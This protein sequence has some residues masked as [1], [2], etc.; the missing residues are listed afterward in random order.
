M[1]PC[2]LR[3]GLRLIDEAVGK[4]EAWCDQIHT[5]SKG[6]D[7]QQEAARCRR[8][9]RAFKYRVRRLRFEL[10]V[11]ELNSTISFCP[12]TALDEAIQSLESKS[13]SDLSELE[14]AVEEFKFTLRDTLVVLHEGVANQDAKVSLADL[15]ESLDEYL[16]PIRSSAV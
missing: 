6:L 14:N 2:K 4:A 15:V 11:P 5:K 13:F 3:D 9:L 8:L 7:M 12:E 16:D 10:S 1:N